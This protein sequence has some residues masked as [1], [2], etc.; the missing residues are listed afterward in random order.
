MGGGFLFQEKSDRTNGNS[1]KL[2]QE[3]FRLH[4]RNGLPR[5]VVESPHP[6]GCSRNDWTWHLVL[7]FSWYGGVWSKV[8]FNDLGLF[9]NLNDS[10]KSWFYFVAM[11]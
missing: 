6:W 4:I 8:R 3:R 2:C 9:S 5:Q 1:L 7:W 11:Q 10:V